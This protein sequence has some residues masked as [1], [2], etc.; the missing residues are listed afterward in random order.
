M[1]LRCTYCQTMFALSRDEMLAALEHLT[2]EKLKYYDAHCPKC[3]RAN[4]VEQFK[5]QMA[6]PNWKADLKAMA[7]ETSTEATPARPAAAAKSAGGK[8]SAYKAPAG[9][10]AGSQAKTPAKSSAKTPATASSKG[11]GPTPA[12]KPTGSAAKTPGT[13]STKPKTGTKTK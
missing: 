7:K 12:K 2:A 13:T 3:R 9:A 8:T 4:R 11:K 6:Y 1:Q 10:S 5:L